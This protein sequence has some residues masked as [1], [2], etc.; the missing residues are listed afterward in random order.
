MGRILS[1]YV[2]NLVYQVVT[3]LVPLF[4]APYLART[5]GPDGVGTYSYVNSMT[6]LICSL[7]M[8]GIFQY[9]NRLC[10]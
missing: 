7:T 6:G 9:G 2:Y 3:L 5:L 10:P 8:L 1:N 4:T